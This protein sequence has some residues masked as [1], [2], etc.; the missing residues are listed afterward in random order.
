MGF[1]R[2]GAQCDGNLF[3]WRFQPLGTTP[4]IFDDKNRKR[5]LGNLFGGKSAETSATV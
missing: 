1:S 4:R 5:H 2:M 3:D